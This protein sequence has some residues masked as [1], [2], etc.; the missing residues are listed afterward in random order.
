MLKSTTRSFIYYDFR[1]LGTGIANIFFFKTNT[2]I[3][4]FCHFGDVFDP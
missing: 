4:C 1:V 3:A 2:D